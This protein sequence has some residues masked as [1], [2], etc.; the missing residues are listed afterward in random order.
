MMDLQR[1]AGSP[2]GM[3]S[4]P[5]ALQTDE[6]L[7]ATVVRTSPIGIVLSTLE[8]G[9]ILEVNA[10]LL[11]MVGYA[12]DEIVGKSAVALGLWADPARRGQMI[13]ALQARRPVDDFETTIRTKSGAARQFMASAELVDI[14]GLTRVL[15]QVSD[16]T[17]QRRAEAAQEAAE[18]RFRALVEQIP[19]VTYTEELGDTSSYS[20]VSPQVESLLGYPVVEILGDR[21][22]F[23]RRIHPDDRDLVQAEGE[24]T[25]AT[26][27]PFRMEY[28]WQAR[29]GRWRRLRDEAVLVRD[30]SGNPLHWQG[31]LLDVTDQRE[32]EAALR[33][34]ERR[35]RAFMESALDCVIA[36]DQEGV[37]TEFNPAAERTFGYS[38]DEA[39]GRSLADLIVPPDLREAHWQGLRRFHE[40]GNGTLLGKRIEI[41]A[42]RAD[43][44]VFP[45]ELAITTVSEPGGDS[46]LGYVRDISSRIE[47][48]TALRINQERFRALVQNSY[49]VIIVLDPDGRR[50]YVSPSIERVLGYSPEELVGGS[51]LDLL[52]PDDVPVLR[53]AIAS[54][55]RGVSQTP[56]LE[57]RFRHRDGD[58]RHFETIG[59]NLLHE[60][61]VNGVVFNSRCITARKATEAALRESEGRFR[62]IFEG[63]G[64][65]MALVD[66]DGTLQVA[67]PALA[68]LLGYRPDELIG[69]TSAAI[70]YPEDNAEQDQ[71]RRRL[72][73]GEID[74]YQVEKRYVRK[75]GDVL[76]GLLNTTAIRDARGMMTAALGQIQDISARKE[77]ESALRESEERFRS[78]FDHAP[79]GLAIVSLDG[80]F[81]QVNWSLCELIGYTESEL[82]DKTFLEITHPDDLA[83]DLAQVARLW[84]GEINTYQLE[85]RYLHKDG[86]AV[87]IQLTVSAVREGAGQRYAIA[88]I[89]DISARRH[90]DLER[91]TMLASEREYTRQLRELADMRAGLTAMVAHELR[92]PVAAL[93]M[94][95]AML[96]TGELVP[97][98][99]VETFAAMHAQI[100]QI[101]R[102]VSDVASSAAAERD[103]FSVQLQPVPLAVLL[104]GAAIF[105]RAALRGHAFTISA[106]TDVRVWC[107]PER[108]SQVLRNL[109]DNA[110][111]HTPPGTPV[112]VTAGD[113]GKRVRIEVANQ[114]PAIPTDDLALIFEKFGR[115]RDAAHRKIA[116]AGLGLYLSRRIVEA[117]GAELSVVSAPEGGTVFG[118]ELRI[119]T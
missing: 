27:E 21:Q 87:W 42:V 109:L 74:S 47:I 73:A 39:I 90:L 60:P 106:A 28:R 20:Y 45:V 52:H 19:A 88:Q 41:S 69:M 66:A 62:S 114:G 96:A 102:L 40:T 51:A 35:G 107:D 94:M 30:A 82:L 1:I 110:A 85:K 112:A 111:K 104:E 119:A 14:D 9:R 43:G 68:E 72:W 70:T 97:A 81:R 77:A 15:L 58:W 5:A 71:V 105:A 59:T 67:N 24:R 13:A 33:Q 78:A 7:L 34:S 22:L 50:H 38:R 79:I 17:A 65:G 113:D 61:G 103:D 54:C 32:A 11:R 36:M 63:A 56:P 26:G 53:E 46:F 16:I 84:A 89:E 12:R 100:D 48:E 55:S 95:T 118:F 57:L 86:H 23:S 3:L 92:S 2:T 115:G 10:S 75:D 64:N 18:A 101:D 37:V 31:V 80:R 117:H 98:V 83:D 44:S 49:D 108:I 4:G 91:A 25:T 99:E 29:D 93:R 76:W 6:D 8:E 116:G